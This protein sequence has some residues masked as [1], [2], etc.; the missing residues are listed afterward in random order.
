MAFWVLI[1]YFFRRYEKMSSKSFFSSFLQLFGTTLLSFVVIFITIIY[2]FPDKGYSLNVL[3]TI[4]L[5][6]FLLVYF[7]QI[8]YFAFKY[9]TTYEE[10]DFEIEERASQVFERPEI[11]ISEDAIAERK[12]RIEQFSGDR[13]F[14]F[15]N[16]NT[17]I[18]SKNTN[19]I[20]DFKYEALLESEAY[21]H[22]QIVILKKLNNIRGINKLFN[23]V[24]HKLPD[25]GLFIC[26]YI[27]QKS[28]KQ[29]LF[30]KHRRGVADIL[31]FFHFVEHRLM[32]K[33]LF[34]SRLYFDI[35]EGQNRSLSKTEVLGRLNYNG[36][37]IE[38]IAKVDGAH[39]VFARRDTNPG[40]LIQKRYGFLIKLKRYGMDGKLFNVYKF[41]TMHPYA[42]YLQDYVYQQ[43]NL[44]E[45]GKFRH[46]IRIT[47]LGKFMRKY[48]LDELPMLYNL[49]KGEMKLVGVR[50]LSAHYFSL[51]SKKLQKM[52]IKHKPGL[53]PPFYAHL[54]KTIEEIEASELLYLEECNEKGTF[55]TDV[56]YFFLILKNIFFRNA[57]SA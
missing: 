7:Y 18:F 12:Q 26:S 17:N 23:L 56:K 54:P 24:N 50:P 22:N 42:E 29:A 35:T 34:G 5:G 1:S 32:P 28:T 6:L 33:I 13:V 48:W 55:R 25:D 47:T 8:I 27:S 3:F 4:V 15:L 10:Y 46:D 49:I 52:R 40:V 53:L 21:Q 39:Y 38:R 30:K 19:V 41:R 14:Q 36:F 57:R 9:A 16:T 11:T 37:K 43:N 51:Y 20:T 45:G 31:Y 44:A 2:Y